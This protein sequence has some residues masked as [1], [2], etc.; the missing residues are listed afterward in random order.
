MESRLKVLGHPR[1]A[2]SCSTGWAWGSTPGR[3]W[4]PRV[5]SHTPPAANTPRRVCN[6]RFRW[7]RSEGSIRNEG[8][9]PGRLPRRTRDELVDLGRQTDES[10]RDRLRPSAPQGP[11]SDR[12]PY[13]S[14]GEDVPRTAPSRS[15]RGAGG[16]R[17]IDPGWFCPRRPLYPVQEFLPPASAPPSHRQ[18][19][20]PRRC[21]LGSGRPLPGLHRWSWR[22]HRLAY[23]PD[24]RRR[25]SRRRAAVSAPTRRSPGVTS[26]SWAWRSSRSRVAAGRIARR[27]ATAG[28][29]ARRPG[30]AGR[31]RAGAGRGAR[32]S[33]PRPCRAGTRPR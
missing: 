25:C 17:L 15:V 20:E 21:G 28:R 9:R 23:G 16:G 18:G 12:F 6:G 2:A 1:S 3:T 30:P 13:N 7:T 11:L 31:A 4:T 14:A 10:P 32:G 19:A 29:R 22:G 27:R 33:C 5:R 26:Y 8:R 24:R